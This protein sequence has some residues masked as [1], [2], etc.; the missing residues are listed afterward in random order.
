MTRK[1]L[2][3]IT[4]CAIL[5]SLWLPL[6]SSASQYD[7]LIER[8]ANTFM[9]SVDWR[10]WKAQV[11]AESAFRPNAVSPVGAMGLSQIMPQ[12][13]KEIAEKSG[14]RGSAFDPEVN[15]MAGA[16]YMARMRNTFK[17]PRPDHERHN[18]AMASYN[19]GAGNI[20]RAQRLAGNPAE[21]QPVADQLHLV[22]GMHAN[23]TRDYVT[24]IRSFYRAY[25]ISGD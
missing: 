4:A 9:P 14:I 2:R 3:C 16:W 17:A 8:S 6:S 20:I 7:R 25:L 22:T 18:L 1:L 23:E 24:K 15:L 13:F 11:K 19:A 5:A 12:T 10:L 21:W